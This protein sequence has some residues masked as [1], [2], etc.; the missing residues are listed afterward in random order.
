[1][2]EKHL[3]L[4][5][6]FDRINNT[7]SSIEI[8]IIATEACVKKKLEENEHKKTCIAQSIFQVINKR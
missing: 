6:M 7:V 5:E 4:V 8:K 2:T 1:M 3:F